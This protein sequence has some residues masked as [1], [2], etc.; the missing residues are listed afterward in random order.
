VHAAVAQIGSAEAEFFPR[1][2]L[3][4]AAALQSIHPDNLYELASG[5][6]SYG[7]SITLP[8]F[9]GGRLQRQVELRTAQEQEAGINYRKAVLQAF[10]DVDNALIALRFERNR[11]VALRRAVGA[12][13]Q[14]LTLANK[15]YTDGVATFLDVLNAQANLLAT[16]QQLA[17][18]EA[19][20]GTNIVRLYKALGGGWQVPRSERSTFRLTPVKQLNIPVILQQEAEKQ[21]AKD[22]AAAAARDRAQSGRGI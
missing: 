10:H 13:R 15:R 9:E 6:Y 20:V 3:S 16:E 1:V 19:T 7:P 4:G 12:N 8:I 5:T 17:T 18:S 22:A 11:A 14:A 2:S 21:A